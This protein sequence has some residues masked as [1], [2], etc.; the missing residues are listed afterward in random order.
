M[1]RPARPRVVRPRPAVRAARVDRAA[2]WV[3]AGQAVRAVAP[4]AP[5]AA[6]EE[7]AERV[8]TPVELAAARGARVEAPVAR[9]GVRA[10]RVAASTLVATRREDREDQEE[11]ASMRPL[12]PMQR[13]NS[14]WRAPTS[15]THSAIVFRRA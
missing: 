14:K 9:A 13:R 1:A 4:A 2:A 15:P 6:Q 5:V 10:A 11:G 8:V 12:P 3:E 7:T